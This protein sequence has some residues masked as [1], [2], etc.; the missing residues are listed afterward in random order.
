M[1]I[2]IANSCANKEGFRSCLNRIDYIVKDLSNGLNLS[3][4]KSIII[5][6]TEDHKYYETL[7]YYA[8]TINATIAPYGSGIYQDVGKCISGI[9]A[10]G[11]FKQIIVLKSAIINILMLDYAILCEKQRLDISQ[12][13]RTV[14]WL[15]ITTILHEFGHAIDNENLFFNHSFVN[16]EKGYDFSIKSDFE[17][18]FLDGAISLWGEFFAESLP[19]NMYPALRTL[20]TSK[21]NELVNCINNYK[22]E[23]VSANDRAFRIINLFVHTVAELGYGNFDYSKLDSF[24][25]YISYLQAIENEMFNLLE[26]YP[27]IIPNTDLN[28]LK[29]IFN[30]LCVIDTN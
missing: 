10:D 25:N 23:N 12:H 14:Q 5:A 2:E 13:Y 29:I 18:Y 6:D 28:K 15:G 27:N 21:V 16:K 4:V 17:Q 7:C 24:P 20:T 11:Q 8:R 26:K 30:R 3:S 1:K 19:F 22:G 9:G